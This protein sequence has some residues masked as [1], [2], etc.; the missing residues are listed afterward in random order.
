MGKEPERE[1]ISVE[2]CPR[3]KI[4]SQSAHAIA[5]HQEILRQTRKSFRK[6][7][8]SQKNEP[9]ENIEKCVLFFTDFSVWK[10]PFFGL[11]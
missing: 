8:N 10:N 4:S 11:S 5:K 9:R 6:E 2:L 7:K 1:P 3:N